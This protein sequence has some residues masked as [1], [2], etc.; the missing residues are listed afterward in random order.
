MLDH[1]LGGRVGRTL[2]SIARLID[3]THG[4]KAPLEPPPAIYHLDPIRLNLKHYGY[5]LARAIGRTAMASVPAEPPFRELGWRLSTQADIESDWAAYWCHELHV[6]PI[7]HRKMWE[8]AY[9][10]HNLWH[11]GMLQSGRSGIGFGCGQ[12]P[13]PS[14]LSSKGVRVLATDLAPNEERARA[15]R[16]TNQHTDELERI[17]QPHLVDRESFD[18]MVSLRHVDMIDIPSDLRNFDFCWSICALE[19]LGSID[20]GMAFV[21]DTLSVLK[22]GGLSVHTTEFNLSDGP[23]IDN[24]PTVLF[25][26]RNMEALADRLRSR[27]H[28]VGPVSFDSGDGPLDRFIDLPPYDN[29]P[30][31]FDVYAEFPAHIKLSIDGLPSTCFGLAIRKAA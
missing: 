5:E 15:W 10:L 7:Y 8:L 23:T 28:E 25:Q 20:R 14:Y 4:S 21:E 29:L 30:S 18:E 31:S 11:Y 17:W 27:G 1:R 13:I 12:E 3:P 19:H 26:R 6:R 16:D 9:V 24:W 22:P 2:R